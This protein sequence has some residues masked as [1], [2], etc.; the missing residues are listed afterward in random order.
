MPHD[1]AVAVGSGTFGIEVKRGKA[2]PPGPGNFVSDGKMWRPQVQPVTTMQRDPRNTERWMDVPV[3]DARTGKPLMAPNPAAVDT[4]LREAGPGAE[5]LSVAASP[6]PK[7]PMKERLD[8]LAALQEAAL[9]AQ[10]KQAEAI[11]KLAEAFAGK[12]LAERR[13]PGPKPKV[14]TE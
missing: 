5:G 12:A 10:T 13:K 4:I 7:D 14:P 11:G 8:R 6:E 9:E 1:G 2:L 3:I